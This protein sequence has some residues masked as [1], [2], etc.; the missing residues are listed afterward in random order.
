G[1]PSFSRSVQRAS[2][3]T[4]VFPE[5]LRAWRFPHRAGARHQ[6]QSHRLEGGDRKAGLSSL[7]AAV[8]RRPVRDVSPVRFLRPPGCT[9]HA[10]TRWQQNPAGHPSAHHPHKECPEHQEQTGDL[11][12]AEG[13][14]ISHRVGRF[15]WRGS[16]AVLQTDPAHPQPV[17]E[18][19]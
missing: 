5:V 10:G 7:P 19:K 13:L 4:H 6:G 12:H 1:G 8:L 14:A 18:H 17:Q 15:G 16:G 2:C 3:Q 11:H 9:R